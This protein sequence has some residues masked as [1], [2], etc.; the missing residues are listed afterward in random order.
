MDFIN[1]PLIVDIHLVLEVKLLILIIAILA[2]MIPELVKIVKLL[3]HGNATH[4]QFQILIY[5]HAK[6]NVNLFQNQ[7]MA[8]NLIT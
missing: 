1:V 5:G 3:I 4:Q 6:S 7:L 2:K 8:L